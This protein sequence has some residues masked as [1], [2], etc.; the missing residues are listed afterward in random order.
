MTVARRTRHSD[1]EWAVKFESNCIS[2]NKAIR[3]EIDDIINDYNVY[4]ITINLAVKMSIIYSEYIKKYRIKRNSSKKK[5]PTYK[6]IV[7]LT[8]YNFISEKCK[9][10][11]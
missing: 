6:E 11:D 8:R 4:Y 2:S 3:K 1:D 9:Y 7:K 10:E 5:K